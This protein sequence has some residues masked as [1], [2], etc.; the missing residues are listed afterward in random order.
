MKLFLTGEI[1]VGK[2]TVIAKTLEILNITPQGFRTYFGPDRG[3]PDKFL[4]M[5]SADKPKVYSKA[6]A[7]AIFTEGNPPQVLVEKFDN[8]GAELI[9]SARTGSPLILMDECGS[10][11]RDAHLFH[12]E[13]LAALDSSIPVLG[14]VK[15]AS[16]GWT[17]FIRNHPNVKLFTVTEKNRDELPDL[18]AQQFRSVL[19]K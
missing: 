18:I 10:L 15:Q 17:D 13:I 12:K 3:L 14:V 19:G 4:Y 5:N 2:S 6:Y 11:E 16:R 8:F 1:Q 9:R 7:V